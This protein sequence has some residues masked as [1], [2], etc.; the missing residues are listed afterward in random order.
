MQKSKT[1]KTYTITEAAELLGVGKSAAYEA[2]RR[3]EI[4]IIRIGRR[5][6]VPKAALERM[7]N[8]PS[9]AAQAAVS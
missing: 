5:M 1:K 4:P 2:A 3:G 8:E 6:V 9:G 7:L